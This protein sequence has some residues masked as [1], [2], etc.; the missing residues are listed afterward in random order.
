VITADSLDV[1][2]MLAMTKIFPEET[3]A[4]AQTRMCLEQLRAYLL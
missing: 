1:A 3:D 2:E 4:A